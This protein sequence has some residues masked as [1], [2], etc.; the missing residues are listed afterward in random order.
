[1]GY[2]SEEAVEAVAS[3]L[4]VNREKRRAIQGMTREELQR[5]LI[6]IYR[7]GFE[8][9]AD[10]IHKHLEQRADIEPEDDIEEVSISWDDVLSVIAEVKGVGPTIL[11]AI[12]SKL[13]EV[14]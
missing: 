9:G 2:V 11:K 8:D 3:E 6:K 12:D 13:K 10:A 5:Y 1:M 4:I 7:S 14:Y